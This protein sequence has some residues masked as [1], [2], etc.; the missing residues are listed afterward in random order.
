MRLPLFVVTT[1]FETRRLFRK[2][3]V[4]VRAPLTS[5]TVISESSGAVLVACDVFIVLFVFAV[6]VVIVLFVFAV[7]VVVAVL[8][9]MPA[10]AV[11]VESAV[12]AVPK[13]A[14]AKAQTARVIR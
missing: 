1:T 2:V 3:R 7:V 9:E 14:S 8:V 13:P 4:S 11:L 10:L 12:Q 5:E 6:V